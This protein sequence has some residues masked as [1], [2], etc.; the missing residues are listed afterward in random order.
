MTMD[1]IQQ[2][3][4]YIYIN[5]HHI[6]SFPKH[7]MNFNGCQHFFLFWMNTYV[8]RSIFWE[9]GY[10]HILF[11]HFSEFGNFKN[12]PKPLPFQVLH[13]TQNSVD[14][15]LS[16]RETYEA[17]FQALKM[18]DLHI[19]EVSFNTQYDQITVLF[20]LFECLNVEPYI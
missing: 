11:G 17:V 19:L 15:R 8:L 20:V 14:I 9:C 16:S 3:I 13:Q 6:F 12:N 4:I 10:S 1:I 7:V 2:N 5:G 18:I